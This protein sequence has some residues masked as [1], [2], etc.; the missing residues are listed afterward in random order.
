MLLLSVIKKNRKRDLITPAAFSAF[1]KNQICISRV[2]VG[3]LDGHDVVWRGE[4]W[5]HVVSKERRGRQ[6]VQLQQQQPPLSLCALACPNEGKGP[7]LQQQQQPRRRRRLPP[8][9][10]PAAEEEW[11]KFL[12]LFSL[13]SFIWPA[14]EKSAPPPSSLSPFLFL[15]LS[16]LSPSDDLMSLLFRVGLLSQSKRLYLSMLHWIN[17]FWCRKRLL[18][19]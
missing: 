14:K 16:P 15:C 5:S 10:A 17:E 2:T 3:Y 8:P 4:R 12:W 6:T 1:F 18:F 9:P 11:G 7:D 19:K 13:D